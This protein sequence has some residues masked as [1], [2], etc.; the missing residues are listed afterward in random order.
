MNHLSLRDTEQLLHIL[1]NLARGKA[2]LP[3]VDAR[4]IVGGALVVINIF[5]GTAAKYHRRAEQVLAILRP[6]HSVR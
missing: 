2:L 5:L 3:L 4:D 6:T 1:P